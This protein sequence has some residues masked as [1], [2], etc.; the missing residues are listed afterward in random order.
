MTMDQIQAEVNNMEK[1]S[2][3]LK[4]ELYKM[5]WF[6]RGSLSFEEVFQLDLNDREAI[7]DIIKENLET[8]KSSGLSFF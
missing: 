4:K 3:A 1:E 5:A 7:A 6:M 2:K 8:T